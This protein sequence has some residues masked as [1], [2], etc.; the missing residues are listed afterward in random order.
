M[1]SLL[2]PAVAALL[3]CICAGG[4]IAGESWIFDSGPY[5]RSATTGKRVVQYQ[6]LPKVTRI[7]FDKFFSEDGPH[8][9]A[10]D[11]WYG[12]DYGWGG[13]GGGWGWGGIDNPG[14]YGGEFP[15]MW[16][17]MSIP[18]PFIYPW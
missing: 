6:A 13:W 3:L 7:P 14:F 12:G 11:W 15:Y 18:G 8:P 9:F 17:D 5:T 16:G 10:M 4:A 1:R 2:N